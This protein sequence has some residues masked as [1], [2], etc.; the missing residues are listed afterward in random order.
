MTA[1][2]RLYIYNNSLNRTAT[3]LAEIPTS[4]SSRLATIPIV[5]RNNQGDITRPLLSRTGTF[6][7]F[8]LS[9]TLTIPVM[10]SENS[11]AVNGGGQGM[12]VLFS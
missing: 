7:P 4:L 8:V 5:L 3:H 12:S 2:K 11:Y 1:L 9:D 10:I 6:T